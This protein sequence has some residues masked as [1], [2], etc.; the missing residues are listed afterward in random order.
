MMHWCNYS[1]L[2]RQLWIRCLQ[3]RWLESQQGWHCVL[4][5]KAAI[6][7]Y[8]ITPIH[9]YSFISF[10]YHFHYGGS[11]STA[12][13]CGSGHRRSQSSLSFYLLVTCQHMSA[14]WTAMKRNTIYT[15]ESSVYVCTYIHTY[16]Y[17]CTEWQQ[18][19]H[20]I[21]TSLT[22]SSISWESNYYVAVRRSSCNTEDICWPVKLV[23]HR[24]WYD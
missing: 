15:Q 19:L 4:H 10:R 6:H 7:Y 22:Q 23:K 9:V 24:P 16:V 18:Y 13:T 11:T 1:V 14:H 2:L 21:H 12:P 17:A 5:S 20:N 3:Q 8:I